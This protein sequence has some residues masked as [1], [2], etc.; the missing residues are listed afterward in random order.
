MVCVVMF[1][2]SWILVDFTIP[3][4]YISGTGEILWLFQYQW[5]DLR[6]SRYIKYMNLTQ[7]YDKKQNKV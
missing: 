7:T 1:Y 4:S 6:E 5:S 3:Q 2:C